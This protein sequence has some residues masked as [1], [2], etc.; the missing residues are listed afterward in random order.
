MIGDLGYVKF[1]LLAVSHSPIYV[2]NETKKNFNFVNMFAIFYQFSKQLM[3]LEL[4]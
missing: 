2:T 3:L 4:M 1:V